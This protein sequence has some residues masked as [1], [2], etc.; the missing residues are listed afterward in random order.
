[1]V[2]LKK[3]WQNCVQKFLLLEFG[4]LQSAASNLMI[5]YC[6]FKEFAAQ[7]DYFL[8][9]YCLKAWGKWTWLIT[10]K[11]LLFQTDLCW[12]NTYITCKRHPIRI[13]D[14]KSRLLVHS[15][16]RL[17]MSGT[18]RLAAHLTTCKVEI[19]VLDLFQFNK[20]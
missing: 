1:M 17:L 13:S 10:I 9:V 11:L 6:T 19:I 18:A 3:V 7:P 2:P 14:L 8:K 4:K 12:H 16:T 5:S 20:F 15:F